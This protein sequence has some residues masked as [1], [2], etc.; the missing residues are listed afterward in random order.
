M[1]PLIRQQHGSKDQTGNGT[2]CHTNSNKLFCCTFFRT[3]RILGLIFVLLSFC[4]TCYFAH[5]D[6][7]KTELLLIVELTVIFSVFRFIL[8]YLW[9]VKYE[10]AGC[11]N[12]Q[13]MNACVC[14]RISF[15]HNYLKLSHISQK[16][17]NVFKLPNL[18]KI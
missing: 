5:L 2:Y 8:C 7:C 9:S 3:C 12:C 6:R 11:I 16:Y 1:E 18:L 15:D 10:I 4:C 17:Q 14:P 13:V